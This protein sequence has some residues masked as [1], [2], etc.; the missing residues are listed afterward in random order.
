MNL[1]VVAVVRTES[2]II[3]INSCYA[4]F[5]EADWDISGHVLRKGLVSSN[6]SIF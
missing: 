4:T 6:V 3:Q 2:Q 1:G 5:V